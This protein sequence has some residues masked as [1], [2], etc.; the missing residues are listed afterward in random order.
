MR[1]FWIFPVTVMGKRV[2]EADVL[3]DLEVRDLAAAEV[4]DLVFGMAVSPAFSLIQA[5]TVSP[6]RASGSPT[7]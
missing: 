7:T 3:R 6:R 4:A 1:N 2:D 5:S